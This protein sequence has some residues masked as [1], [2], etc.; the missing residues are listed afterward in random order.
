MPN[1]SCPWS[2]WPRPV[3]LPPL[4]SLGFN[5]VC[6]KEWPRSSHFALLFISLCSPLLRTFSSQSSCSIFFFCFTR[7]S[8]LPPCSP[9]VTDAFD[10]AVMLAP[11]A[12]ATFIFLPYFRIFLLL[13]SFLPIF[14]LSFPVCLTFLAYNGWITAVYLALFLYLCLWLY[15]HL[16]S[17]YCFLACSAYSFVLHFL[18]CFLFPSSLFL[19]FPHFL[20]SSLNLW[21]SFCL[22][23]FLPSPHIGPLASPGWG[24][25]PPRPFYETA[26]PSYC[27]SPLAL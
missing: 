14:P 19:S 5:S 24:S 25:Y 11:F 23:L 4:H 1:L 26:V 3:P 21:L 22:P 27:L 8:S 13:F 16:T 9:H 12:C 17:F 10:H 2:T 15:L 20:V 6:W 7:F 18:S